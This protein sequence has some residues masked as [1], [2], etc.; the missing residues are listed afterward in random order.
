MQESPGESETINDFQDFEELSTRHLALERVHRGLVES[1]AARASTWNANNAIQIPDLI[2]KYLSII[3][4]ASKAEEENRQLH[5]IVMNDGNVLPLDSKLHQDL[6][7]MSVKLNTSSRRLELVNSTKAGSEQRLADADV[8]IIEPIYVR[9]CRC[10]NLGVVSVQVVQERMEVLEEK[11]GTMQSEL[12]CGCKRNEELQ[13]LLCESVPRKMLEDCQV[14]VQ[15]LREEKMNLEDRVLRSIF[16]GMYELQT[17]RVH[18][19]SLFVRKNEQQLEL[20]KE[21]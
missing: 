17:P 6:V 8:G 20:L 15:Q 5:L 9:N 19:I 2:E 7:D 13:K 14:T 16:L 11:L 18:L 12:D 3:E 10:A 21:S 4:R 1:L